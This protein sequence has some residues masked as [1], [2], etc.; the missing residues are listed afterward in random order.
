MNYSEK[1]FPTEEEYVARMY[2]GALLNPRVD[3]TFKALFTQPTAES[4]GALKSFLEA[5]TERDID[6]FEF[7]SNDAPEEFG[8]QRRVSYDIACVFCDGEAADIEM[9]AFNQEYDYGKRAEYQVSRLETTYLKKGD[10]WEKAPKVYQIT[11]LDFIYSKID[12]NNAETKK[13][14]SR[15][16]MR[17]KDGRELSN[18][19][20]V[21]FIE[22]P[23][24][25][26]LEQ[27][28]DTNTRL[29]NWALFLK[30]ADNPQKNE[31]IHKLTQKEAGLMQAQQSLSNISENR[32]LW[33]AEY[34]K[35][36]YERDRRS[37]ISAAINKGL[38]Q[39]L[40]RGIAQG[41]ERGLAQ[42]IAQGLE[43]GIAQGRFDEKKDIVKRLYALGLS[44][45]QVAQ[46]VGLSVQ[47][48]KQLM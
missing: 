39:G 29:E 32:D 15:Y 37:S 41:L 11:V 28:L 18:A 40:E 9:Q 6:S 42:G 12:E 17:T 47:D 23:K 31:L 24:V 1:D 33:I 30:D 46:G 5:A 13:P 27:S 4:R 21:I 22:L 19:L 16:S 14:V 20:N 36:M 26:G 43:Q 2:T 3:S 7:V 35:E 38:K 25:Q 10:T 34:R 44:P 8:G 45:E 48:I